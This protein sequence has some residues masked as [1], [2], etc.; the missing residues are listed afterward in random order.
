VNGEF[1]DQTRTAMQKMGVSPETLAALGRLQSTNQLQ[2]LYK[3]SGDPMLYKASGITAAFQQN[4][5]ISGATSGTI[6]AAAPP[7]APGPTTS[8]SRIKFEG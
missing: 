4:A 6:P 8:G 5:T 7:L 3:P 2:A 1:N